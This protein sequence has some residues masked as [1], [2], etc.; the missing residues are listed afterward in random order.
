MRPKA[1]Q[2]LVATL[3]PLR[4]AVHQQFGRIDALGQVVEAPIPL[5][6]GQ[7]QR[8]GLP[9][10]LQRRADLVGGPP[11]PVDGLGGSMALEIAAAL[12]SAFADLGQH[13]VHGLAALVLRGHAVV[14]EGTLPVDAVPGQLR[15][16]QEAEALVEGLVKLARVVEERVRPLRAVALDACVQ[17]Q[18]V[19]APG[20]AER[21]ELDRTEG[22]K[23]SSHA[24]RPRRQGARRREQMATHQEAARRG[25]ADAPDGVAHSW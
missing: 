1:R 16:G 21:V 11:E 3:L 9:Q 22:R 4:R 18:I 23:G 2:Q 24:V 20:N 10:R 6:S 13:V 5:A 19:V 15:R 14:L 25:R 17:D 7:S 12:R 8:A